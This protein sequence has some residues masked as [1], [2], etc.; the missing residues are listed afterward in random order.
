MDDARLIAEIDAVE[1]SITTT[2]ERHITGAVDKAL[3]KLDLNA[4]Y[5]NRGLRDVGVMQDFGKPSPA[6]R[7]VLAKNMTKAVADFDAKVLDVLTGGRSA[8]M[9]A[10]YAANLFH[11]DADRFIDMMLPPW[12]TVRLPFYDADL[13]RSVNDTGSEILTVGLGM[14]ATPEGVVP[15]CSCLVSIDHEDG[16]CT[17]CGGVL[18]TPDKHLCVDEGCE[19]HEAPDVA[20]WRPGVDGPTGDGAADLDALDAALY[21][22]D[23]VSCVHIW[24]PI[25]GRYPK[26]VLCGAED[27]PA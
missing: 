13:V 24:R 15:P 9:T 27:I 18:P 5:G 8:P 11:K 23:A 25:E 12:P 14:T 22:G 16:L 2:S 26:C 7:D 6:A 10:A 19:H 17:Q 3:R 4:G 20:A 1:G 21:V